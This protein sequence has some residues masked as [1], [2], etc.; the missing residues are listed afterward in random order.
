MANYFHRKIY[1]RCLAW[2][3]GNALRGNFWCWEQGTERGDWS[4]CSRGVTGPWPF[5]SEN[6]CWAGE[7][8]SGV[9]TPSVWRS[10]LGAGDC[11]IPSE[12]TLSPPEIWPKPIVH[13]SAGY[14]YRQKLC[15]SSHH[16][17]QLLQQIL[18]KGNIK[19]PR[20]KRLQVDIDKEHV[21]P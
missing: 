19:Q 21:L 1:T 9:P 12:G 6:C 2:G 5:Y 16:F 8:S 20:K 11:A 18:L 15:F 7:N 10:S 3:H 4:H 13:L 17:Q 14:S